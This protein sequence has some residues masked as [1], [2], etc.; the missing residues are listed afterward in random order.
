MAGLAAFLEN[1]RHIFRECRLTCGVWTRGRADA[2]AVLIVD[3]AP[4]FAALLESIGRLQ[5][6]HDRSAVSRHAERSLNV[7]GG[8][9]S[10]VVDESSMS[11]R[12]KLSCAAAS[13]RTDSRLSRQRS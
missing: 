2:L 4:A 11:I 6:V 5:G 10:D 8:S 1:R 12:T 9:V 7:A 3:S 13:R